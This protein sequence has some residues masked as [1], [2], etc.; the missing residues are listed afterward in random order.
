MT[1]SGS[2]R[3]PAWPDA[4]E[5]TRSAIGLV[6]AERVDSGTTADALRTDAGVVP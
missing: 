6:I 3:T 5:S 1:R 4:D 2:I